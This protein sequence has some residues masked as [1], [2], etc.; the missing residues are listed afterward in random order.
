MNQNLWRRAIK[1]KINDL[2]ESW[3]DSSD[4][5]RWHYN[6]AQAKIWNMKCDWSAR[7]KFVSIR[8]LKWDFS[9][10]VARR[11]SDMMSHKYQTELKWD[12]TACSSDICQPSCLILIWITRWNILI[13]F[14]INCLHVLVIKFYILIWDN[15]LKM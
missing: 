13:D 9:Q 8:G 5:Y 14:Y 1:L 15:I 12:L 2:S 4:S 6:A 11:L 7:E 10:H 3:W